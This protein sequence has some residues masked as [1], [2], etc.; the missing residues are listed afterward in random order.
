MIRHAAAALATLVCFGATTAGAT[1]CAYYI[2]YIKDESER[3]WAVKNVYRYT[4]ERLA[5]IKALKEDGEALCNEGREEEG[6]TVLLE[7]VKL[8]SFTMLK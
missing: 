6:K 5:Q 3:E 8:I 2:D 7:A 1:T 4:P